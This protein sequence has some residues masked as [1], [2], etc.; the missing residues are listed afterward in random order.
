MYPVCLPLLILHFSGRVLNPSE[1]M[2]IL[3]KFTEL[4]KYI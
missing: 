1:V 4:S 2:I 3:C